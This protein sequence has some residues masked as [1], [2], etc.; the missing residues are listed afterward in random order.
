MR[1]SALAFALAACALATAPLPAQSP[2]AATGWLDDGRA[3]PRPALIDIRVPRAAAG[4]TLD[5]LEAIRPD[6]TDLAAVYNRA[7]GR[8]VA[9]AYVYRP[10][11]ADAGYTMIMTDLAIRALFGAKVEAP[12]DALVAAGGVAGTAHRR[13]YTGGRL[14]PQARPVATALAAL[15]AGD[16]IVKLRVTGPEEESAA[17]AAALDGLLAGIEFGGTSRPAAAALDSV[18]SCPEPAGAS[19]AT[20]K[21]GPSTVLQLAVALA[22]GPGD[23]RPRRLCVMAA[24]STGVGMELVLRDRDGAAAPTV[25]LTGD[26]GDGVLVVPGQAPLEGWGLIRA[27]AQEAVMFGP[28]D[29][30]PSAAQLIGLMTGQT[31]WVGSGISRMRRDAAGAVNVEVS[32]TQ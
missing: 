28:Y 18:D 17:V 29:R 1:L 9:T 11:I 21:P 15:R 4:L 10:G 14:G 31:D 30:A 19:P 26:R 23:A 12:P 7:D 27:S 25:M 16:W 22:A 32:A 3:P 8:I 20:R 24:R 13:V 2:P 5:K 6:G